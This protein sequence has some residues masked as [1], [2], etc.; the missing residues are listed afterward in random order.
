M[1]TAL[2]AALKG[3]YEVIMRL[4]LASRVDVNTEE[5]FF[6]N[7]LV[8]AS[9][10]GHDAV[11][12]RSRETAFESLMSLG[13]PR[14]QKEQSYSEFIIRVKPYINVGRETNTNIENITL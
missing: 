2:Y 9:V 10:E 12:E 1:R 6:T 11:V 5:R 8:A 3:V 14:Q 4:L 7:A 13:T